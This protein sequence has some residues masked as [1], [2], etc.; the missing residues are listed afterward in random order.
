MYFYVSDDPLATHGFSS[1]EENSSLQQL[2]PY[3]HSS[4]I[5]QQPLLSSRN[6]FFVKNIDDIDPRFICQS[7]RLVLRKPYQ[8]QCGHRQ[9][10]ACIDVQNRTIHCLSCSKTSAINEVWFDA[11]LQAELECLSIFC[12]VCDWTGPLKIYQNHIDQNH[13]DRFLICSLCREQ[14]ERSKIL[15]H[16]MTE[17][18][19][20]RLLNILLHLQS[21]QIKNDQQQQQMRYSQFH[22]MISILSTD[23]ALLDIRVEQIQYEFYSHQQ[24]L[25]LHTYKLLLLKNLIREVV[26]YLYQ[27]RTIQDFCMR[28]VLSLEH[29]F[30]QRHIISFDGILKW[31]ISNI[32]EKINDA[33]CERQRSIYSPEFYT[34]PTGY[35]MRARLF[36]NGTNDV[37]D[38]YISIFFILMRGEYDAILKWPF[39]FKVIF[40][41]LNQLTIEDDRHHLNEF[42]WP[43]KQSICFQRPHLEMNNAYGIKKFISLDKFQQNR[44]QYVQDDTIFI[45]VEIDFLSIPP[46]NRSDAGEMLMIDE[47]HVDTEEDDLMRKILLSRGFNDN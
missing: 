16:Y 7:C 9:C 44:D 23:I 29:H 34:S 45:K 14:V 6:G 24:A 11:A 38:T 12:S 27:T 33:K 37:Q 43:D 13:V 20:S 41:L 47:Q 2:I 4:E 22:D 1:L 30:D 32:Q 25:Q 42:F 26:N 46:E 19:Q 5:S 8:L 3:N 35:K 39:H 15:E 28:E 31:K 17:T 36:L 10:Q 18:H 21:I 40:S